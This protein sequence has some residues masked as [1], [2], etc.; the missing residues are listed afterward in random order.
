MT[1]IYKGSCS[2]ENNVH[3]DSGVGDT[4]LALVLKGP[5]HVV[6]GESVLGRGLTEHLKD[7]TYAWFRC[8]EWIVEGVSVCL[9]VWGYIQL[10]VNEGPRRPLR[11]TR[12]CPRLDNYASIW[13][14]DASSA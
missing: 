13:V 5:A 10:S 14:R 8:V 11:P 3:F 1:M 2:D 7:S 12:W 9:D 6:G 4:D